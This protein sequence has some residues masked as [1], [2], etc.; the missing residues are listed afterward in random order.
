MHWL[1]RSDDTPSSGVPDKGVSHTPF[2]IASNRD[3]TPLL[4]KTIPFG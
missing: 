1:E 3:E 4:P 2:A